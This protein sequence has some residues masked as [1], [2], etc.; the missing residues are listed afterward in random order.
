MKRLTLALT[1]DCMATRGSLISSEPAAQQF[2]S[3]LRSADFAFTNLEVV[4][5]TGRGHPV[6]NAAGGGCL[7]ADRHIVDDITEAGFNVL[8]C[9]NNHALDLGPDGAAATAELL[10]SKRI[11]FAGIGLDLTAARRPVYVDRP[12]GSLAL[13]ACSSTFLPGQEASYPSPD[14]RGRPGLS[15]LRHSAVL[16]VT[17]SQL[18]L[19]REIDGESGLRARRAEARTLLGFD[20]A[21]PSPTRLGLFGTNFRLGEEPAF[22]TECDPRD[23]DAIALWVAE[24]RNRADV[25]VVSVH[26]HEPGATPQEP[27]EFLRVFARRMIDEGADAVVGHGPHLLRG[28]EIHRGKPIFYSLGNIVSQIDLTEHVP[29][30][31]YAN[32]PA[33]GKQTPGRYFTALSGNGRRLFAPHRQY[34][35][36]LVPVLAFE[37]GK[38][39]DVQLHPIDLGHGR[40]VH[41]RGRPR[42]AAPDDGAEILD[43]FA[44]LSEPYGTKITIAQSGAGE[45]VTGTV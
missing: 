33:D 38:L 28:M 26:S 13:I 18:D 29:A 35:Q 42:I 2:R 19:L 1:G 22:T 39:A 20:P 16:D 14:L 41:L 27:S 45:W 31:D 24:A 5:D 11:P 8:G 17:S 23:L 36:S 3:I 43:G 15:P 21:M 32:V 37:G 12:G 34:W 7:I 25:V 6:R 40:D 44:H 9:A 30:E 4:P 10:A